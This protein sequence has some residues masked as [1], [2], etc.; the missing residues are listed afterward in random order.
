[1]ATLNVAELQEL[2]ETQVPAVL[3]ESPGFKEWLRDFIRRQTV[4]R[5]SFDER[6]ERVMDELAADRESQR[7]HWDEQERKWSLTELH[8][9]EQ[10]RKWEELGRRWDEQERRWSLTELHMKEQNRKW[11]EQSLRWHETLAEMRSNKAKFEQSVGALG[12]RW[13][14][15]SEAAFRSALGAIL[16]ES[17]GVQ[18]YSVNEMDEEG[19]VF[20][21]PEQVEL[22]VIIVNGTLILCELKSSVSKG[23]MYLFERK[24]RFYAK[25][26]ERVVDR[27]IVVS[28]MVE[29]RARE[30]AA[31]LGIEVYSYAEDVVRHVG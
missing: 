31:E 5:E 15:A 26:H 19:M 23:E 11:E 4:P 28:P 2:L 25:R 18:V 24:A 29:A 17:F 3:Q 7:R 13:G 14:V 9:K 10:N 6:F 27:R 1:M 16:R 20:G 21:R 30:V 12:A 8:I 22:D